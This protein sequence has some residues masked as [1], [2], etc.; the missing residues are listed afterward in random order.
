M[1]VQTGGL[2]FFS[3]RFGLVCSNILSYEVVLAS[4]TIIIA[5]ASNNPDLWRAL[6]GGSNNFGI[7]TRFTART[8]PATKIW[9]GF[10]YMPGSQAAKVLASFYEFVNR[11][12][13]GDLGT[14]YDS[15]AAGPIAC[16]TYLQQLGIQ[17]VS[18]H[19]CYTNPKG[20]EKNWPVCWRSSSFSSLWRF[21]STCKV[22][23]ITNATN[24]MHGLNPPGRRQ[25]E[26]TTTI[27]NDPATLAGAH[28]AY[29]D[30]I[31]SI[32]RLNVKGM[33]WTLVLQPLLADW[34]RRGD[35]NPLGLQDCSEPLVIISFTVNWLQSQ[36]D[37]FVRA[38]TRRAIEQIEA[39]A[40]ANKTAHPYRFLNY[41]G[42][43]QK[44]FESYGKENRAF[45]QEVSKR[46]DP[47]GLFQKG[48]AGGFKLDMDDKA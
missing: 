2:S 47:N 23:T 8:F 48:C 37:D 1:K 7:V 26:A 18:A 28:T 27:Q 29:R 41:C 34:V 30:A 20:N 22:R 32:R 11:T 21:W 25:V 3:P 13:T 15:N 6:K 19:L 5:S 4:G 16:F 40:I 14:R 46:Y 31:T 43:W 38:T 12:N 35:T 24:E 44:P 36:D 9:S 45:L 33:S 39:V 10:L 17:L 42:G